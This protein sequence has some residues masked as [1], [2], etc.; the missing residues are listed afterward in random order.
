MAKTVYIHYGMSEFDKSVFKPIK[1]GHLESKPFGGLWA[2]PVNSKCGWKDWCI[3][4]G[5]CLY[6]LD[7]SFSFVLTDDAKVLHLRS[8]ADVDKLPIYCP[9]P[10][11]EDTIP[12]RY[13]DFEKL[14]EK[15]DAVEL[16][17]P[18]DR[19]CE[20][21]WNSIYLKMWSWDCDSILIMNPDIIVPIKEESK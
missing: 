19:R 12:T 20:P 10:E 9:Y 21:Y 16:H 8:G 5:F 7:L 6:K 15:Y 3:S 14:M 2:S 18:E 1:N 13:I 11:M 4:E 17:L